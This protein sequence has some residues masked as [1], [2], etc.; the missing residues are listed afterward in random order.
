MSFAR[1]LL[2]LVLMLS[3]LAAQTQ[4]KGSGKNLEAPAS[5]SGAKSTQAKSSGLID[6]NTATEEELKQLPGI[7]DADAAKIGTES[8]LPRQERAGAKE[9]HP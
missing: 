1:M 9:D 7:G 3:L 8:A 6:I 2:P 4:K 5:E